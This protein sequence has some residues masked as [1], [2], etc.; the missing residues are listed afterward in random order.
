MPLST[1]SLANFHIRC[2][3]QA[4]KYLSSFLANR[5]PQNATLLDEH[6]RAQLHLRISQEFA[7]FKRLND[8]RLEVLEAQLSKFISKEQKRFTDDLQQLTNRFTYTSPSIYVSSSFVHSHFSF[9][10][11]ANDLKDRVEANCNELAKAPVLM[12]TDYHDRLTG[13]KS[14]MDNTI[15]ANQEVVELKRKEE[16]AARQAQ[17]Q[18]TRLQLRV[19]RM[20]NESKEEEQRLREAI[21]ARG[22]I[23]NLQE[24]LGLQQRRLREAKDPCVVV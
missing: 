5:S 15:S 14:Q 10:M 21:Q 22:D 17:A 3:N 24:L 9:L 7:N 12:E 1:D 13:M 16:A 19:E 23:G 11:E 8:K 4:L 18:T 20:Q 6:A 2:E